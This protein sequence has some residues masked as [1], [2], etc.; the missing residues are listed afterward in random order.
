MKKPE[1]VASILKTTLANLNLAERI[2]KYSL[3][4]HWREIVGPKIAEKTEPDRWMDDTLVVKVASHPWMT[5]LTLM[6]PMIVK[7]IRDLIPDVPIR[8]IRFEL[9][10]SRP[11]PKK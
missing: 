10:S 5:E 6:K 7:K 3:W 1:P 4:E 11:P 8:N 9:K 2:Q